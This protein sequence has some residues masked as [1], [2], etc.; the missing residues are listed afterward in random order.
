MR[1]IALF[2]SLMMLAL[3]GLQF[4]QAQPGD[5]ATDVV[6]EQTRVV[7]TIV[8]RI[9]GIKKSIPED[10]ADD[11]SLITLGGQIEEIVT[12]LAEINEALAPRLQQINSRLE[13]LGAPPADEAPA[14]AEVV[15]TERNR[16]N[17]EKNAINALMSQAQDLTSQLGEERS[18]VANLRRDLFAEQFTRRYKIDE[19]L[20]QEI[21]SSIAEEWDTFSD[22][23]GAW[24]GFVMSAKLAATIAATVVSLGAAFG[25]R[26]V[27]RRYFSR[28]VITSLSD[29][30]SYLGRLSVAFG[31][32]LVAVA[33]LAAFLGITFFLFDYMDIFQP[34]IRQIAQTLS[35]V[36][37]TA[38]FINRLAWAILNPGHPE[39]RLVPVSD[40][41]APLLVGIITV[42]TIMSGI[43]Y[44]TSSVFRLMGSPVAVTV[45]NSLLATIIVGALFGLLG[46]VR[47]FMDEG[48]KPRQWRLPLRLTFYG[49]GLVTILAALFGYIG[50]ARFLSQ[51]VVITGAIIATMYI[52]YLTARAISAENALT[53]SS[54]GRSFSERFKL[55]DTGLDQ[56][57]LFLGILLNVLVTVVGLPFIMLQWGFH[58]GDLLAIGE[59]LFTGVTV[60]S[61]TFSLTGVIWGIV[62]FILG[63]LF[64]RWFQGWIDQTVMARGKVDLGLRNSIRT[65]IGYV[66]LAVAGIIGVSAAGVDLSNLALIAGG[67]SLGIGFGLQNIVQNFVSGLILLAERPFK[68]GDWIVA[69]TVSGTVKKISVRATEIE[70]FQRQTV[71]LPNSQLINSEVGNWT[72]KNKMGRCDIKLTIAYTADPRKVYALLMDIVTA[73]PNILKNPEPMVVFTNMTNMLMDFEVRFFMADI[74]ATIGVQN[75]I[76]FLIAETFAEERIVLINPVLKEYYIKEAVGEGEK[77]YRQIP[78]DPS[79]PAAMAAGSQTTEQDEAPSAD[80]PLDVDLPAENQPGKSK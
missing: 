40:K 68:A 14:E 53:N 12:E 43:D 9:E 19:T 26:F 77:D 67:L 30:P 57:G 45:G 39:W 64:V 46:L 55:D 44:F 62:V 7:E 74:T 5:F 48:G 38:F 75:E 32:T 21:G 69:G 59:R 29:K 33:S 2:M 18:Q 50:L 78:D 8:T 28:L 22:I 6:R 34:V 31:S 10:P 36:A 23:I 65:I 70:T 4:A 25:I 52:G 35:M 15:T 24:L 60:G 54:V 58:V 17:A 1:L 3:L 56:L 61:F 73:H 49:L 27:G 51:Q 80:D 72:H 66:G 76:R 79:H 71:I 42:M 13:A 11:E 47:P 16:L 63:Y 37:L 20:F 41:A